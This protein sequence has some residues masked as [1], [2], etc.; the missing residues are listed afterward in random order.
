MFL[1]DNVN[2][3]IVLGHLME[4]MFVSKYLIRMHQDIEVERVTQHK[5]CG[6]H[7]HLI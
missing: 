7:A 4:Y 1:R 3:R 5:M 2:L 6:R